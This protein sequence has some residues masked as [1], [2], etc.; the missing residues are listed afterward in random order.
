M[1]DQADKL[2]KLVREAVAQHGSLALGS[3]LVAMTGSTPGVGVTSLVR[4]LAIEL[5]R[6]GKQVIAVD[7]NLTSPT[8]AGEFGVRPRGSIS[9]V[10]A[11]KRRANV[12]L[13]TA[14][15]GLRVLPS[16]CEP[17]PLDEKSVGRLINEL[18]SLNH[19]SDVLLLDCGHGMNPWTNRIWQLAAHVVLVMTPSDNSTLDA[20]TAVKLADRNQI[21]DKLRLAI[22]RCS[23][24][25]DALAIHG[26]MAETCQRFL[27]CPLQ[28]PAT[29]PTQSLGEDSSY[30][31]A[32]RMLAADLACDF[33]TVASQ[34]ASHA[35]RNSIASSAMKSAGGDG[36][37]LTELHSS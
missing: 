8:L 5:V 22:N 23:Q 7:V 13:G 12:V 9:D 28:A 35:T 19:I 31:R 36:N 30:R 26:R 14:D 21:G 33:R 10:L 1:H 11:G 2:R 17:G 3:P 18:G 6:L 24:E 37:L 25:S 16:S 20:Y 29:I 15:H 32:V 27:A 34:L 4:A